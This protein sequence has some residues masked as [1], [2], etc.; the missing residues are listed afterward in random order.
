MP[1]G[2]SGPALR[3]FRLWARHL[4]MAEALRGVGRYVLAHGA[5]APR[6]RELLILRTTARCGAEYEWGVHAVFFPARV[7]LDAAQ[8]AAT[9][10]GDATNPS[11]APRDRLLVR[12]AD[13]LHDTATVSDALWAELAAGWDETQ[14]L[15]MLLVCGFYH[16]V[17][18]TANAAR[19]APEPFAARFPA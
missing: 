5:L 18:F 10:R 12:L 9:A 17:S 6:D 16:L 7:G 13:E 3:L 11:L 2:W 1:K 8:V 19:L 4:P 14:L 15:E